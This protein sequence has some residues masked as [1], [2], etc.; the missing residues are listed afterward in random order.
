MG[1][2]SNGVPSHILS[3]WV[4]ITDGFLILLTNWISK[5]KLNTAGDH[6]S[7]FFLWILY[8]CYLSLF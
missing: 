8:L 1:D 5:W 6:R 4:R 2:V 7:T 3:A